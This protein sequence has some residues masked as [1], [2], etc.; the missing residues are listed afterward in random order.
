MKNK[1]KNFSHV[2]VVAIVAVVAS[3]AFVA[4]LSPV[5]S[6]A[7]QLKAVEAVD[8]LSEKKNNDYYRTVSTQHDNLS[9]H[10]SSFAANK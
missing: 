8:E 6:A 9:S 4:S 7:Q 3:T 5:P 1:N 10:I 2:F